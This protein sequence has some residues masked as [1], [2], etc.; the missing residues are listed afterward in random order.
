M[1]ISGESLQVTPRRSGAI[2]HPP[3]ESGHDQCPH[4]GIGIAHTEVSDP[5]GRVPRQFSYGQGKRLSDGG[6]ALG[7]CE[8]QPG[9]LPSLCGPQRYRTEGARLRVAAPSECPREAGKR[10][11]SAGCTPGPSQRDCGGPSHDAGWVLESSTQGLHRLPRSRRRGFREP[12]DPGQPCRKL[13]LLGQVE[14]FLEEPV[15]FPAES[16]GSNVR[17]SSTSAS[18]E[19]QHALGVDLCE[20]AKA[21]HGR[22]WRQRQL[23]VDDVEEEATRP[24]IIPSAST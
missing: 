23:R 12:S 14:E 6:A 1:R 11:V 4:I 15:A 13:S 22:F 3:T 18:Q 8:Q 5:R 10:A 9:C 20:P 7:Q 16:D 24:T 17:A 2:R 21:R 19:G